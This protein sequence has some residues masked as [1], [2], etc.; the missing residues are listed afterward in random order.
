MFTNPT[1]TDFK[2]YFF[3]DF[4]YGTTPEVVNDQDIMNALQAAFLNINPCL[5]CSQE[6]YSY[7]F[8]LLAAHYLTVSIRNSTQGLGGAYAFPATS[9][10]VGSV[11]VGTQ[12]PDLIASNPALLALYTTTYGAAYANY[13]APMLVGTCFT[14]EGFTKP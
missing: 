11:S 6:S 12:I 7:A 9:K 8:D 10:S 5:F 13:V 3:R 4:M 2:T 1:V 14:T